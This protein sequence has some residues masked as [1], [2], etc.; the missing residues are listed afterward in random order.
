MD[1]IKFN[2]IKRLITVSIFLSI[3]IAFGIIASISPYWFH[4]KYKEIITISNIYLGLY[5]QKI[6]YVV[7]GCEYKNYSND[8]YLK[9]NYLLLMVQCLYFYLLLSQLC[10]LFKL[11]FNGFMLCFNIQSD[12]YK[13]VNCWWYL[14]INIVFNL[15]GMMIISFLFSTTIESNLTHGAEL[16][17]IEYGLIMFVLSYIFAIISTIF[18]LFYKSKEYKLLKIQKLELYQFI[19]NPKDENSSIA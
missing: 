1:P 3:S 2:N 16:N 17:D 18:E 5:T 11:I 15:I 19:E 6:C 13:K 14:F 8:V 12:K 10:Y 9:T 7:Y 4:Y